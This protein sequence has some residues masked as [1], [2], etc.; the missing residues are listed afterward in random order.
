MTPL[1]KKLNF[2][3][4]KTIHVI[5]PPKTFDHE[6][7]AMAPY[8]DIVINSKAQPFDFLILFV[9]EKQQIDDTIEQ[10]SPYALGDATI[11]YCYPKGTSKKY[12][13]NFNRDTGWQTV[14]NHGWEG[15]R[16]VAI[17]ED[18]SALRIR[19]VDYI[20]TMTRSFAM[21]K[22]GKAKSGK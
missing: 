20:K 11:W 16:M 6:L 17:D 14:G 21:T 13:C 3:D 12:K 18:W 5:Q 15:V 4:H 8:A 7:K 2:K 9:T 22:E 1:F 19:K 10:W